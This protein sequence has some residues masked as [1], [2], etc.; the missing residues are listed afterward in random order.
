MAEK[1][2]NFIVIMT[3]QH[4]A[5][6]LGC[7]GH[8][9]IKTPAID[10]LAAG[11][12]KFTRFYVSSPVCMPNRA[13]FMTGRM[14]SVCGA[15]GNGIP[16]SLQSN[17]FVELLRSSGYQTSLIGKSHLMNIVPAPG[18]WKHETPEG[19]TPPPNELSEADKFWAPDEL[20]DQEN[21]KNWGEIDDWEID[22]P[23]YGFDQV[24]L[25]IGHGDQVGG[26]YARWL[27][28]QGID[29]GDLV[30]PANA[31]EADVK[32]PQAWRTALSEEHYPSSYIKEQSLTTLDEY[33][34]GNNDDPFFMMVSFP[35][36]HHP[37][38]PPGKYWDMY[39]PDQ[40]GLPN[41]FYNWQSNSS[42]AVQQAHKAK[43]ADWYNENETTAFLPVNEK[44]AKEAAALTC[45]M[46]TMIDDAIGSILE[47]L[48]KTGLEEN[49]VIIFTSDHGEFL[50]DY[51]LLLK[52]PLHVNS[53]TNVPFI[54]T[55]PTEK[56]VPECNAISG[57]MDIP[58]TILAR[59]GLAEFN[60]MQG[61]SLLPEIQTGKDHGR[62]ARLIEEEM[63]YDVFDVKTP[64]RLRT[65]VTDDWRLSIYEDDIAEMYDLKND[66]DE[67]NNLWD[68]PDY[69]ETQATLLTRMTRELIHYTDLS[70]APRRRA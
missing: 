58:S 51:G 70:P 64:I 18:L 30:G 9:F 32:C 34:S 15:R 21:P 69:I 68:E 65:L 1:Q 12:T 61:R 54:Y 6:Y 8:P 33:S 4:R 5:D 55:D 63:Q 42:F 19:L 38:T 47:R 40:V 29:I 53:V 50:G 27:K 20:Y 60:G 10:S 16:L 37:F 56:S 2:P 57:T 26:D 24:K 11:G 35:D 41:S 62:G 67:I 3:D 39:S 17:T 48:K 45:G 7:Y 14:P 49:T 52:G 46:I 13:S 22:L 59:A 43:N 44:Q 31:L 23:F 25:C 66:P 28:N 36:P